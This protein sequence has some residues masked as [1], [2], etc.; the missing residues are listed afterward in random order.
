MSGHLL[1]VIAHEPRPSSPAGTI[2]PATGVPD[3]WLPC[4]GRFLS[5]EEYPEL[6]MAI[7]D[8]F[9][10]NWIC[11]Q[12]TFWES[13]KILF[14][15]DVDLKIPNP[16]YREGMFRIPYLRPKDKQELEEQFKNCP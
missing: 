4:D 2:L 12:P 15:V 7:G 5:V 10:P 1:Y 6:Y 11:R 8:S 3:G 9:C 16:E 13:W 14:G